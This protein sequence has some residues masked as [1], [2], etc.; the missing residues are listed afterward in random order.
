MRWSQV[1]PVGKKECT[2]CSQTRESLAE[3][4]NVE[5]AICPECMYKQFGDE[6]L[7]EW[8]IGVG[9]VAEPEV[10]GEEVSFDYGYG[11]TV[12]FELK[13][14]QMPASRN[15]NETES[16]HFKQT[17]SNRAKIR[18][19]G[20]VLGKVSAKKWAKYADDFLYPD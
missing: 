6:F 15:P 5:E 4:G 8:V 14:K 12:D 7:S 9:V 3:D 18:Y 16:I 1:E 17:A 10:H 11:L 19:Q 2:N 13:D 20:K